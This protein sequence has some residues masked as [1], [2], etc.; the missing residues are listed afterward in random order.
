MKKLILIVLVTFF[1]TNAFCQNEDIVEKNIETIDS[2]AKA[3]N[4]TMIKVIYNSTTTND[5][6][7]WTKKG[8]FEFVGNFLVLHGIYYNLDKLLY[9]YIKDDYIGIVIQKI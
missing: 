3:N 9:F 8:E 6:Q 7:D 4:I 2:I 1:V 5:G